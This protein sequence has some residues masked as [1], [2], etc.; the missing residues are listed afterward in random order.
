MR[1]TKEILDE[2]KED[3]AKRILTT[4]PDPEF[5]KSGGY[6][7]TAPMRHTRYYSKHVPDP[8]EYRYHQLIG[9]HFR[10]Y[11]AIY[12]VIKDFSNDYKYDINNDEGYDPVKDGL[13]NDVPAEYYSRVLGHSN[14]EDAMKSIEN[15]KAEMA[16]REIMESRGFFANLSAGV[17]A[18]IPDILL[19]APMASGIKSGA[20]ATNF[21]RGAMESAKIVLPAAAI[22][23][24]YVEGQKETG[25]TKEWIVNTLTE[26]FIAGAFGGIGKGLETA[27]IKGNAYGAKVFIKA[28]VDDVDVKMTYHPDGSPGG[29]KAVAVEGSTVSAKQVEAVDLMIKDGQPYIKNSKFVKYAFGW[30]SPLIR[31]LTDKAKIV[32][33]FYHRAFHSPFE[34]A[35]TVTAQ[36]AAKK[37]KT[38]LKDIR[39]NIDSE[40]VEGIK[41]KEALT[42]L[43]ENLKSKGKNE[44]LTIEES[45]KE[46][47]ALHVEQMK[48]DPRAIRD[49]PKYEL[50]NR[51]IESA[52]QANDSLKALHKEFKLTEAGKNI[53]YDEFKA[54]AGMAYRADAQGFD[55]VFKKNNIV[56]DKSV[57]G[58][59]WEKAKATF[60]DLEDHEATNIAK[61]L[62]RIYDR[63]KISA[64]RNDF[65]KDIIFALEEQNKIITDLNR[66]TDVLK[67]SAKT[68]KSL[69]KELKE[70]LKGKTKDERAAIKKSIAEAESLYESQNQGIIESIEALEKRI[71]D[72][73]PTIP[74]DC[75]DGK[76]NMTST[77]K[78]A[79]KEWEKPIYD[80]Q[81]NLT[82]I[83]KELKTVEAK[84]VEKR[85]AVRT[86]IEGHQ[87]NIKEIEGQIKADIEAAKKPREALQAKI[88]EERSVLK[89][90]VEEG[91]KLEAKK[92]ELLSG[93]RESQ[94]EIKEI[95]SIA[96]AQAKKANALKKKKQETLAH[97]NKRIKEADELSRTIEA[98][99]KELNE[100]LNANRALEVKTEKVKIKIKADLKAK[101]KLI[102]QRKSEA[103]K[104][105]VL[106]AERSKVKGELDKLRAE[107]NKKI[108]EIKQAKTELLSTERTKIKDAP[109]ALSKKEIQQHALQKK[110]LRERID[111]SKANIKKLE[112]EIK[113]TVTDI[114][115]PKVELQNKLKSEKEKLKALFKGEEKSKIKSRK[116]IRERI[117]EAKENIQKAKDDLQEALYNGDVHHDLYV[118]N[119]HTRKLRNVN[120]VARLR[121]VTP[122][123]NLLL[124]AESVA[125]NITQ[126]SEQ[127]QAGQLFDGIRS[128][129]NN[130]TATRTLMINDKYLEKWLVNDLDIIASLY[131]D[132]MGRRIYMHEML[133]EYSGES[134]AM[135]KNLE[136]GYPP[137]PNEHF[138]A[139]EH[140]EAMQGMASVMLDAHRLE[141]AEILKEPPSPLR[142]KKI[143]SVDNLFKKSGKKIEDGYR[144]FMGSF[145]DRGHV[146]HRPVQAMKKLAVS[147]L[148]GNVPILMLSEFGLGLFRNSFREYVVDG[149]L[150]GIHALKNW[151]DSALKQYGFKYKKYI[152]GRHADAG[153][154][155]SRTMFSLMDG[156]MGY[157]KSFTSHSNKNWFEKATDWAAKTSQQLSGAA[158]LMDIQE[159]I[160]AN[161]AETKILRYVQKYMSGEELL[162]PEIDMLDR[163]A[164]NPAKWGERMSNQY[165]QHGG[166]FGDGFVSNYHLWDDMEVK[167]A[168][169]SAIHMDVRNIILLP[170]PMDVPL[171]MKDPVVGMLSQFMTY[172]FQTQT[173]FLA[174]TLTRLDSQ[175]L[176]GISAT[177]GIGSMVGVLR[178]LTQ[179]KEP[180]LD[181]ATLFEEAIMNSA[182][183][184]VTGEGI[185]MINARLDSPLTNNAQRAASKFGSR[186]GGPVIG[187]GDLAAD[188]AASLLNNELNQKDNAKGIKLLTGLTQN[189]W[190]RGPYNKLSKYTS[191]YETRAEAARN[192]GHK[193]RKKRK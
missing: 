38:L 75:L 108:A 104:R 146:L 154:G 112:A 127:Q 31:G 30:G 16:D 122:K 34:S 93:V 185:S 55:P 145:V 3:H 106:R 124:V 135:Q 162:P 43:R 69:I 47:E 186:V 175:K 156:R 81:E 88:K 159:N 114:K 138:Y 132:Q 5:Y 113:D 10:Q 40:G 36:A 90:A 56:Y 84:E 76:S 152:K 128:G 98:K 54:M 141:K 133:M 20:I 63:D 109:V 60:K 28:L 72:K 129:G 168:F 192:K 172:I 119:G 102:V 15:I 180:D 188:W 96:R 89:D 144:I 53:T 27:K 99:I 151:N 190:T 78:A 21:I 179:G 68:T 191:I 44:G 17:I 130:P 48:S 26:G 148:L 33:D 123:Q 92:K 94:K 164:F 183:L 62:S 140:R 158:G 64:N 24:L 149:I 189:W 170:G 80:A 166:K 14:K 107:S 71:L 22:R 173:Q 171:L 153:L 82:N 147:V 174:P 97:E 136:K 52:N 110:A 73:D 51:M 42:D 57:F 7:Q 178:S 8:K 134:K 79:I 193:R 86:E 6:A 187:L 95:Q 161:I 50:V 103:S 67:E 165:K 105:K 58:P 9:A 39:K 160:F 12:S 2:T 115:K 116:D 85:D 137:L 46:S 74:L 157:E 167:R 19:L 120:D 131:A 155:V 150:P 169:A 1:Y 61:F 29:L 181:P 13:L 121:K 66:P 37:T 11:N 182:I 125:D 59:I 45:I 176:I 32:S 87:S 139:V 101:N 23:N 184:G 126:Q 142:D 117:K 49:T 91:K 65:I 118:D 70:N 41:T 163:A 77:E 143:K 111:K 100:N 25:T 35:H 18:G 4:T 83:E 177:M